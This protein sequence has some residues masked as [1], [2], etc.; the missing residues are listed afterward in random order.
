MNKKNLLLLKIALFA[1]FSFAW[2]LGFGQGVTTGAI[3][4]IVTDSKGAALPGATI[5][6]THTPSGTTYG[7][8]AR[9]DGRFTFP[10]VRVGGPYTL[11]ISFVGY[12]DQILNDI[13]ISLGEKYTA[14][15]K[16]NDEST[17][18]TE[19]TVVGDQNAIIN[20]DRTGASTNIRREQFERLP[21]IGRSFQEMTSLH[22][23]AGTGFTFG[24]RS[25][26][27]NNFSIDG[28][29]LNNVFGLNALP[30]GQS[31]QQPV[32]LDALEEITVSTAPYDVRQGSFTG[33]GINAVTRSGTNNFSGSVYGFYKNQSLV[34]D[35]VDGTKQTTTDFNY[36]NAGFRL[37]GPILKDK[38]FFFVNYEDEKRSD[39]AVTFPAGVAGNQ[40][41]SDGTNSNTDLK[42]LRD[43]ITKNIKNTDGTSYDPGNY[44]NFNLVTGSK[45]YLAKIDW[46]INT[47]N[48]LTIRYTQ[49]DA[50]RDVPP[51]GS[52]GFT[53][54]PNGGRSNG[55]NTLPF[56]SSYYRINN[57]TKSIIA[58]LN[59]TIGNKFSNSLTFGYTSQRDLRNG[60]GG[61]AI[62]NFPLVDIY[63]PNGTNLTSFG[64]EPF[65]PNN[66]LN[67]DI[68]QLNDNFNIYLKNNTLTVGTA[69]EYY[70]F[71][72]AFTQVINGVYQYSS[73]ANFE[74]NVLNP[75]AANSPTLY[76]QQYSAL[77]G[78]SAPAAEWQAMQLGA[79]VQD[80][81]S[82]IKNLKLTAGIRV[83]IPIYLTSL[84]NNT[85]SDNLTFANGEK[86]SVGK[87]PKVSPLFSPRIGFNWD[88]KGDKT[89]QIRGG[90]GIFTGRV[91]FV[92][93]SNQVSN[94]GLFFGT[95]TARST[96]NGTTSA[97]ATQ[98]VNYPFSPDPN[99]YVPTS[100]YADLGNGTPAINPVTK[101]AFT[102][103]IN[104]ATPNFKFPQVWRTNIAID[105]KLPFGVI[106][107][108]E[109]VYTKDI[110]A[111]YF[112]NANLSNSVGKIAGDGR[113]LYSTNNIVNPSVQQAIVLDNTNK[114]Y[115]W[116][117]TGQL[118]KTFS[119]GFYA[120]AAYTYTD[121]R[122]LY[123][124]S[125]STAGTAWS[126]NYILNNPNN[127]EL[128]YS[129]NLTKHRI[130][131]S[132][133]YRKEYLE[134]F[135]TTL[136]LIY[137]GRSGSPYS[138][139]YGNDINGDGQTNDLIYIPR[140]Q[141]EILLTTTNAT[142]TRTV[143]QIWQQ[144]DT[145]INQ[146]NYLSKHRG[147]YMA[148]NAA[149]SPWVHN[150]LNLRLL[151]DFH[152]TAG[153]KRNT[154]QFSFELINILN[155]L[156]SKWG[157]EQFA[158]KPN[159]LGFAGY[160][161]PNTVTGT[162]GRP[163]YTFATN[164]NG[165]PLT[166]TYASQTGPIY[167]WQMQFGLRYIFN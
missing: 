155:L 110:N 84:P 136:S 149:I 167:R 99:K 4:G 100:G 69:N 162:S 17:Q 141:S 6:A 152:I 72:N 88:V 118:Q 23:Q 130:V 158:V 20:S 52:N 19:I 126:G 105:Q 50:F 93:L 49:V 131:A 62:L 83:D 108:A 147:E 116:S 14:D 51:S 45:K 73:I 27:Y 133:S 47:A 75:T 58:E 151:Q 81:Y 134:H 2:Q 150:N 132:A 102:F 119:K 7:A 35:K 113:P 34:G 140:N 53:S 137:I 80:E 129:G 148:R 157:M 48:K 156:D 64:G 79:Y 76:I 55:I 74:A 43:F 30:S 109:F 85:V 87:F 143:D 40:A 77:K 97:A 121:S 104:A 82:G 8:A 42:G 164:S 1:L 103:S 123:G 18:L 11:K 92:W 125:G 65:T 66:K 154:L 153:G 91:P 127:P 95:T 31:A 117:L 135:A 145:Y 54:G 128:S 37:G 36:Y 94:N 124:Q 165:T 26:L 63:G 138:Y 78:V 21:S 3:E 67:T 111:I 71:Y 163:I 114:G 60:V 46:N 96:N 144:L 107:T 115:S 57:K 9:T 22:P 159:L 44:D 166:N 32:S 68:I 33:A 56:S 41:T 98:T 106:G 139:N 24:G 59:T 12:K 29:T 122:D 90:T 70:K 38:L 39:P 89:T 28:S 161:T 101:S 61:S 5:L 146:D 142:D 13:N 10:A 112:R 86:V 16:L 160:E 15:A 25:S 120:A